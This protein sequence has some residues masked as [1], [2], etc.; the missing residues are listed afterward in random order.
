MTW[1]KTVQEYN[2][3]VGL[4]FTKDTTNTPDGWTQVDLTTHGIA[5]DE[6]NLSDQIDLQT[7]FGSTWA[8]WWGWRARFEFQAA[9]VPG[10][11]MQIY[12]AG[13][14]HHTN[15]IVDGDM[16]A[17]ENTD[18]AE[19]SLPNMDN[20]ASVNTTLQEYSAG[21]GLFR[22]KDRYISMLLFNDTAAETTTTDN[23]ENWIKL[24]P[25]PELEIPV[26]QHSL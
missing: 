6:T 20:I 16:S 4:Y 15:T 9:V 2:P 22:M 23:T 12:L 24:W 8:L 18:V 26:P 5:A 25:I 17:V 19:T 10:Q 7:V 3:P 11:F 1:T 21:S 14:D 13:G